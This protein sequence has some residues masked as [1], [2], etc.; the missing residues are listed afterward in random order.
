MLES[1][2]RPAPAMNLR[3]YAA[4]LIVFV[5]VTALW[6]VAVALFNI[7]VFL[8]PAPRQILSTFVANAGPLFLYGFNTFRE[9]IT[10]FAIGCSAGILIAL[11]AARFRV[12]SETL[13][14]IAVASNS[15]PI[16]A[17]APIAIVWFGIDE[18]SKIAIVAV[19]CLFPT[20]VSMLRG[21]QS[22]SPDALD[23]MRS[24][25]A[26]EWQIFTKLRLPTSI[27]FLFNAFRLCSTLSIIAA[28]VAEF[29]GG[30]VK[31]LGVY[32]KTEANILHTTNAWA[33][34][35]VACII[36]IAFYL[37]IGLVERLV[38]PWRVPHDESR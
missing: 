1:G 34:I 7:P 6:E 27:P 11:V 23:L 16:V 32:I 5:A 26:S 24:Y 29:F 2:T 38:T 22:A 30:A 9:A 33:A 28:I 19:S 4:P 8:L 15:I 21:L 20:F 25:A 14:P 35:V 3:R 10:G 12:L 13:A 17:M 31:F 37:L 18:G 36:G